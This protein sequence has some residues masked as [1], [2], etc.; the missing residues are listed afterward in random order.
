MTLY[1][2]G[3]QGS[4]P[5]APRRPALALAALAVLFFAASAGG[6][7]L[8]SANFRLRGGHTNG[9]GA[10]DLQST[11]PVPTIGSLDASI[12]QPEA[13]GMSGSLVNLTTD[14]PG[15]WPIVA[16]GFPTLDSDA[17]LIQA[18]RDNCPYA[19]NPGQAP[20]SDDPDIGTA[21]LCGDVD[22]SGTVDLFDI[23]AYRDF[24]ADPIGLPLPPTGE[25][26]CTV[27]DPP[28]PCD[29]LDVTVI[30]REV[31]GPGLPPGIAQDCE[32]ARPPTP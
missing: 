9:G 31:E 26:K 16:R 10:I 1:L 17:D 11:A 13:I 30:R 23:D 5:R 15:F 27:I 22:D 19:S 8:S 3:M 24:L 2:D 7:E 18:F 21:C 29:E 20:S 32:A 12:G 14:A 25:A 4:R 6:D 28:S